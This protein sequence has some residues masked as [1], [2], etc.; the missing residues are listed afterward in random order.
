[1]LDQRE[2]RGLLEE[3]LIYE[4]IRNLRASIW[5]LKDSLEKSL[6]DLYEEV[7]EGEEEDKVIDLLSSFCEGIQE[8]LDQTERSLIHLED[9]IRDDGIPQ[10]LERWEKIRKESLICLT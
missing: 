7:T 1:M 3:K 5:Y 6:D 8:K 10:F 9:D 4:G 2:V